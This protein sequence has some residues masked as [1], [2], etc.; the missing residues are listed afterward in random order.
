MLAV[1]EVGDVVHG[2]WAVEGVHSDE[3]LEGAGLQ[4][5]QVLL[6]AGR[7][8]LEGADGAAL[9]VEFVGERVVDGDGVNIDV[10]AQRLLD[11]LHSL[12][13]DGEG[14]QSKEVHFD[15][16]CVFNDAAFVLRD[17]ELFLRFLVLGSRDR[18]PVGDVIAADDGATGMDTRVAD[19]ALEHLGVFDGVA[20]QRVGRDS[21]L[22]Q[23]RHGSDSVGEVHLRRLAVYIG[24]TVGDGLAETVGDVERHFLHTGHI[25]DGQLGSH[26]AVSDDVGHLLLSVLVGYPLQHASAPVVVEVNVYIGQR[27]AVGIEEALEQQVVFDG[28]DAGNL[29]AVGHGTTCRRASSRAYPHAQFLASSTDEVLHDEEVARESHRLHDVE[30]EVQLVLY[31]GRHLWIDFLCAVEGELAQIVGLE[32]DAV[33]LVVAAQL[34]NLCMCL[35]VAQH[36]I[37]LLVAGELV[38]EVFLRVLLAV[39]LLRAEVGRDVEVG[40]DGGMVDAVGLH[41]VEDGDGVVERLGHVAED[42][43]HLLGGLEPFLLRIE[44]AVGVVEVLAR[45]EA[46]EAV[47]SLG[48]FLVD[49]VDVVGADKGDAIL[50][51][52]LLQLGIDVELQVIDFVVGAGHGGLVELEF[53]IVVVAEY[54]LVPLYGLLGFIEPPGEYLPRHLTAQTSRAD[55]QSLVVLLQFVA[56]GTRMAVKAL[57]PRLRDKFHEVVVALLV[58]CQHQ[59]VIVCAVARCLLL[60]REMARSDVHLAAH[61]RLEGDEA[62]LLPLVVHLVHVV[63]ELLDAHHV[64]MVGN[65][66][67]RHAVGNGFLDKLRDSRLPIEDRVLRMDVKV[68]EGGHI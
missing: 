61:D 42:G 63:Q 37:T 47:V 6:H 46:D 58:L 51:A 57:R 1:D 18:H 43:V 29:Q 32:L 65:G 9:A 35:L 23:L 31:L 11:V 66:H 17:D 34:V 59:Q 67:A 39:L 12:L 48:V 30:L 52:V 55:N 16:A 40:H 21:R 49:E 28:V 45:A 10:N 64:A 54:A 56:V 20:Q 53:Q 38:K 25:L 4:L 2:A 13:K 62:L 68:N 26:R 36:H 24:Q 27:Y 44:H 22:L 15:E 19:V 3:V 41:L 50:A 33:E 60:V 14:F 5:A 7:L 8:K